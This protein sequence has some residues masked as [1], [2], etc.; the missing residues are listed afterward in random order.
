M[1][2][3]SGSDSDYARYRGKCKE[4]SEALIRDRP[5]L[6][7]R[8]VRGHYYDAAWG[9]QEHWWTESADGTV[10]DPTKDQF[11]S[12]GLGLY[13]EFDGICSCEECGK[14]VREEDATFAGPY[15]CC[16]NACALRLVG[17]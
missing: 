7:L 11:P 17:L 5:D 3:G 2:S 12:K 8:L 9:A 16:S 13:E 14:E 6:D 4:M 15:P 10:H 1:T